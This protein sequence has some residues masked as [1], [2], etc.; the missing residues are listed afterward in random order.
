MKTQFH[1]PQSRMALAVANLV[2]VL[3]TVVV[4]SACTVGPNYQRPNFDLPAKIAAPV[5]Q[6]GNAKAVSVDLQSWWRTFQDPVLQAYIDESLTNNQDLK[7]ALARI[8]EARANAGI[9]RANQA[10]SVDA[11]F[12]SSR[13]RTSQNSGKLPANAEPVAKDFQLGL[14]VAYEVDL[15][16]KLSRADEA[17]KARLLQQAATRQVVQTSLLANV[18]QTYFALRAGDAQFSLAQASFKNA[19]R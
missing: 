8:E 4:L 6:A 13:S 18:V 10:P 3:A 11:S 5:S 7:I 9:A 19:P 12:V 16:G 17:A 2:P 1:F 14:S 15:F